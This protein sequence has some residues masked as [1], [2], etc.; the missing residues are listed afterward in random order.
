MLSSWSAKK[1]L[2]SHVGLCSVD[3]VW[4]HLKS[5]RCRQRVFTLEQGELSP[6]WYTSIA[7]RLRKAWFIQ[8]TFEGNDYSSSRVFTYV[9]FAMTKVIPRQ[10]VS[11]LKHARIAN[12]PNT[13]STKTCFCALRQLSDTVCTSWH[14]I[15]SRN[16]HKKSVACRVLTNWR[17]LSAT[18]KHITCLR[19]LEFTP[20]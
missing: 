14:G 3:L 11:A 10:N 15:R 7:P 9:G 16:I 1:L 13:F 18:L 20:E 2:A 12:N 19:R 8:A 5:F 4:K 6:L 17:C